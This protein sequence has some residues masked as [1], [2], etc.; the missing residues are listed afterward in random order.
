MPFISHFHVCSCHLSI[1]KG[2]F[3]IQYQN[4]ELQLD[5]FFLPDFLDTIDG[6]FVDISYPY[7]PGSL[8]AVELELLNTMRMRLKEKISS[9]IAQVFLVLE[10][11]KF[12]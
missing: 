5:F 2:G 6:K 3:V 7:H 10:K 4:V 12:L 9:R 8:S 11:Q 1:F